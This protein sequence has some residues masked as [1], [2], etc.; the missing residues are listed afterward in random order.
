MSATTQSLRAG[1][2]YSIPLPSSFPLS[3]GSP[4][5]P[6]QPLRSD[7]MDTT[8]SNVQDPYAELF[9]LGGVEFSQEEL[10]ELKAFHEFMVRHVQPNESCSV[11]C[12]LVW[13][14][15]VRTFRCQIHEFPKLIKEKEFR[16]V[17]TEKY[18]V[19]IAEDKFRGAVF[20]GLR[21]VP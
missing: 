4:A 6:E 3:E 20:P 17:V 9:R 21:F 7:F 13:N 16:S 19:G 5:D 2:A 18:G 14:E 12:M 11:Q 8:E 1:I 15:W 10:Q